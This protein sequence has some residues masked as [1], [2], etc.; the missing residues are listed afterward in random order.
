MEYFFVYMLK[1]SDDSYYIGHSD[2]IEKRLEEHN[3]GMCTYTKNKLPLQM[4]F[5][6]RFLA[7]EE[8]IE[9]EHKIKKWTRKK[10]E[11]LIQKNWKLISNL[12][13]KRFDQ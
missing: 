7:R 5:I 8:A 13:K 12:S 6:E 3:H 2:N 10:K 1:C 9:A 4:V 11:A